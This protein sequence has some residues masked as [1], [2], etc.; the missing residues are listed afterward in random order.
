MRSVGS[1]PI[2]MNSGN[3]NHCRVISKLT[4]LELFL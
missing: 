1:V 4:V 2:G 3:V